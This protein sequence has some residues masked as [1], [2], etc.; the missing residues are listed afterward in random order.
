MK[1]NFSSLYSKLLIAFV[2]HTLLIIVL[3]TFMTLYYV[4]NRMH[5]NI[6]IFE[7]HA[8]RDLITVLINYYEQHGSFESLKS[9]DTFLRMKKNSFES[10]S[11]EYAHPMETVI[12]NSISDLG[13]NKEQVLLFISRRYINLSTLS[14]SSQQCISGPCNHNIQ[15]VKEP[16][17]SNGKTIGFLNLPKKLTLSFFKTWWLIYSLPMF[18]ILILVSVS[19]SIIITAYILRPVKQLRVAA[20]KIKARDFD[21]EAPVKNND[22]LNCL[23]QNY[24]EVAHQLKV[25]EYGQKRWVSALSHELN[26]P[27]ANIRAD[28][29]AM[30]D[31][32]RKIDIKR[33]D[34]VLGDVDQLHKL[35]NDLQIVVA[36]ERWVNLKIQSSKCIL[37]SF[38]IALASCSSRLQQAKLV[39]TQHNQL[40]EEQTLNLDSN[41]LVQVFINLLNNCISYSHSSTN[42]S[43][44]F[45]QSNSTI[46]VEVEDTGPGV[47][48]SDLPFIFDYLYRVENSRSRNTGG[49]GLGLAICKAIIE[50]HQGQITATQGSKGGLKIMITLPFTTSTAA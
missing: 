28:I 11:F 5:A 47:P 37:E 29:Q 39:V 17:Q 2:G 34:V 42:I 38:D 24:N 18:T 31:G 50:S 1:I 40:T 48:V 4:S 7:E 35:I 15:M 32:V 9:N 25:Y 43:V 49:S 21:F 45:L 3:V 41:K 46:V 19:L 10:A 22:E 36:P 44:R 20:K 30:H 12:I 6:D 8:K 23:L 14:S 16:I 33:L 27:L 13:Q 26:S